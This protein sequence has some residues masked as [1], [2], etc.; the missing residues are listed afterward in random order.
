M[1]HP[2]NRKI[3]RGNT[4]FLETEIYYFLALNASTFYHRYSG[5]SEKYV[6]LLSE[7]IKKVSFGNFNSA[8]IT[9]YKY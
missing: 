6:L 1:Q 4:H 2:E 9:K 5:L 8:I 7:M 3:G